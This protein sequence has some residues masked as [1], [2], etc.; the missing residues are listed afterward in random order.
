M[1]SDLLKLILSA[2]TLF[3]AGCS[4]FER[5][6]EVPER[7]LLTTVDEYDTSLNQRSLHIF[8]PISINPKQL[9]KQLAPRSDHLTFVFDSTTLSGLTHRGVPA[10]EY[11]EEF[12][13]RFIVTADE[14]QLNI[15]VLMAHPVVD[16]STDYSFSPMAMVDPYALDYT[17]FKS[18]APDLMSLLSELHKR[19][20][21]A[22]G[23]QSVVIITD[24]SKVDQNLA[25]AVDRLRQAYEK[26]SGHLI[27]SD[28]PNWSSQKEPAGGC[29]YLVGISNTLS[30]S[31]VDRVGQCGFSSAADKVMQPYDMSHFV[32][33]V[34]FKGPKDSDRDGVFD[35]LDRCANTN[36]N[37]IVDFNGCEKFKGEKYE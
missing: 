5:T 28:T 21:Q 30:R 25:N 22:D 12:L 36:P 19:A 27:K 6:I 13:R 10:Q 23:V 34:L 24:W 31:T 15:R 37:A 26:P 20:S 8:D 32:E 9:E 29:F 1:R 14:Q 4:G 2:M 7:P 11:A 33:R 18:F 35:Y 17:G 16:Y 3:L